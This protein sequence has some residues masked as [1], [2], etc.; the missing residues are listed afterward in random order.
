MPNAARM[1]NYYLGGK[2]NFRVDRDAAGK[3]IEKCPN[4]AMVA[5]ANRHFMIRAARYC[6]L[7]GARQ[8]VEMNMGI[9]TSPSVHEAV[10]AVDP[11][12]RIVGVAR[13]PVALCHARA[14][15]DD[16]ASLRVVEGDVQRMGDV[17]DDPVLR[18]VIDLR[19]PVVFLLAAVAES[20]VD[21]RHAAAAVG[22]LRERMAPGSYLVFSHATSTGS[23]PQAVE[24]I[25]EVYA[26][27]T[28]AT[29]FRRRDQIHDLLDGLN[30]VEPGLVDV[31]QWHPERGLVEVF[32]R[33][34]LLGAVACKS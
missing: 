3:V 21:D 29:V 20:I 6:A 34:R 9:P 32:T 33:M 22:L 19:E 31:Q 4:M 14:L 28:C 5:R 23:D 24:R 7:R 27:S 10:R 1:L 2:D 11:E 8:F 12:A 30:L 18:Q 15:V 13:D 17:L 25:E 26:Q 16:G